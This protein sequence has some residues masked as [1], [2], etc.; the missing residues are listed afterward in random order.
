M[1]SRLHRQPIVKTRDGDVLLMS[2]HDNNHV[3]KRDSERAF[4]SLRTRVLDVD[5][6]RRGGVPGRPSRRWPDHHQLRE[7]E[8]AVAKAVPE[9]EEGGCSAY[10]RGTLRSM[11]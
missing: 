6:H 10:P 3:L 2:S 11:C 5:G 8:R 1:T 9:L 4:C 7:V